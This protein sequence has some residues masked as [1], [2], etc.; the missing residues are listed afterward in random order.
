MNVPVLSCPEPVTLPTLIL[1]EWPTLA[2]DATPEEIKAWYVSMVETMRARQLLRD[3]RIETL[4]S[5]LDLY[6]YGE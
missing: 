6:R 1:P 2:D 5:A 4:N 3:D